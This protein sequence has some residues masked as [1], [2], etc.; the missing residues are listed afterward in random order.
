MYQN[1]MVDTETKAQIRLWVHP[2]KTESNDVILYKKSEIKSTETKIERGIIRD[3]L[4]CIATCM[5]DVETK[6]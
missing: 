6:E 1:Y 5:V 3:S 2:S 4:I